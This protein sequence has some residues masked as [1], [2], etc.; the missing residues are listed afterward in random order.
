MSTDL[1][2]RYPLPSAVDLQQLGALVAS[3]AYFADAR[4]AAQAAVKI[5]AGA[6]LG[7]GPI[8]SMRG[9]DIIK[10]EVSLSAGMVAAMVRRSGVYDYRVAEWTNE[11]CE[12]VFTRKGR[13]LTPSSV[14]DLQDAERAGLRGDNYRKFPRN[15]LFARAMTNGARVHCPEVFVGAVYTPD[16][17]VDGEVVPDAPG[18]PPA[19]VDVSPREGDERAPEATQTAPE[20]T[21]PDAAEEAVPVLHI[22]PITEAQSAEVKRLLSAAMQR[23]MTSSILRAE[24]DRMGLQDI[25]LV[26]GWT[27][28]LSREKASDLIGFLQAGVEPVRDP[29]GE[30]V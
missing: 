1:T 17:L 8:A 23:G 28:R 10:G 13:P 18:P 24:L 5:M 25:P 4:E 27:N 12:I 29:A 11:R 16:E 3:S 30:A 6:E 22:Y 2:V 7:I 26:A 20:G 9:I 19:P 21:L 15:M 14:F